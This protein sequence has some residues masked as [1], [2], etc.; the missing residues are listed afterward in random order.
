VQSP[1]FPST[2]QQ[3][4]TLHQPILRQRFIA[5]FDA[6]HVH[7]IK[8]HN[9]IL[10][11][12]CDTKTGLWQINLQQT[13]IHHAITIQPAA[14]HVQKLKIKKD[15]MKYLHWACFSPVPST[16]IKA[17]KAGYFMTVPS[18]TVDLV[19]KHLNQ[20]IATAKGHLRHERQSLRS[21]KRSAPKPQPSTGPPP[22][23][24]TSY[25]YKQPILNIGQMHSNQTG[26]FPITSS[27]G[28]KYAM[29]VY[30]YDS[31]AILAEPLT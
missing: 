19:Q 18:L 6:K 16:W 20:S 29:V 25:I 9:V 12:N 8:N 13:P 3:R 15:I 14:N 28:S 5:Q 23:T 7:I 17:I 11:G 27:C 21:T 4:P 22:R 24:C 26:H 10:Q 30:G 2:C 31:N 1:Y